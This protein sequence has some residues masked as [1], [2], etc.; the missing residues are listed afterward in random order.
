MV[1]CCQCY[2]QVINSITQHHQ[3]R[4]HMT[5]ITL[6]V[7]LSLLGVDSIAYHLA[8]S[9]LS[10]DPKSK[11]TTLWHCDVYSMFLHQASF[12]AVRQIL[13]LLK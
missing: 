12:L 4:H 6:F 3:V 13:G 9:Q 2:C 11:G 10:L 5:L 7:T 1:T 8:F